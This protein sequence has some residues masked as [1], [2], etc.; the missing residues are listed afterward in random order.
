M[1]PKG[2]Y[3]LES[4]HYET[5][6]PEDVRQQISEYVDVIAPLLT[7]EEVECYSDVLKEAQVIFSGW[8]APVLDEDFLQACPKLQVFFT[9]PV[10]LR[11]SSRTALGSAPS[12]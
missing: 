3:I 6:Y 11:E 1:K 2:L 9:V 5:I 7:K 4:E 12:Y 10:L 8:G